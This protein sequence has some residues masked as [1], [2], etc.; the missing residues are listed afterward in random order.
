M[1]GQEPGSIRHGQILASIF[2]RS[3]EDL[4]KAAGSLES[5]IRAA[6][7]SSE[8]LGDRIFFLNIV[9]TLATVVGAFAAVWSAFD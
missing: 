7:A 1:A 9:L 5:A 8:R 2:V 6:A 4:E 3:V